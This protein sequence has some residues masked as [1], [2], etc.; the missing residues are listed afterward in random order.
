M[1]TK[2]DCLN[3]CFSLTYHE[4]SGNTFGRWAVGSVCNVHLWNILNGFSKNPNVDS[5]NHPTPGLEFAKSTE[6][7]INCNRLVMYPYSTQKRYWTVEGE[8]QLIEMRMK[9]NQEFIRVHGPELNVSFG[10]VYIRNLMK[11]FAETASTGFL[12]ESLRREYSAK[13]VRAAT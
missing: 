9:S 7:D 10:F 2:R 1:D 13:T 4:A 11:F 5:S 6:K 12:L 8:Q 3:R